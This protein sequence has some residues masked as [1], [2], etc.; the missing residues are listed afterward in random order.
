M[1]GG[2]ELSLQWEMQMAGSG[3]PSRDEGSGGQ[4]QVSRYRLA[5]WRAS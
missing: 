4:G 3:T 5:P 2:R 1:R